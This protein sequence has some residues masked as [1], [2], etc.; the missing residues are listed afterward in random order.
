MMSI[1]FD[2]PAALEQQLREQWADLDALAKEAALVELY[3][4][5]K[6]PHHQ[7]ATALGLDRLSTDELLRRHGV[8]EDLIS[9]EA[10]NSQIAALRTVV[11]R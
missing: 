7:L 5:A 2:L 1:T 11:G 6:L 9:V 4:Q 10:L 8:T 3:R